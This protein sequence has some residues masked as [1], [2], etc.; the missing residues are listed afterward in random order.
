MSNLR[1]LGKALKKFRDRVTHEVPTGPHTDVK[2][3]KLNPSFKKR[4]T[5]VGPDIES[6]ITKERKRK[7]KIMGMGLK[8]VVKRMIGQKEGGRI[9]LR[10][11]TKPLET[12]MHKKRAQQTQNVK[13]LTTSDDAYSPERRVLQVEKKTPY[14]STG[15]RKVITDWH[16]I[17]EEGKKLKEKFVKKH[18][19]GTLSLYDPPKIR[20]RKGKKIGAA[21]STN[22]IKLQQKILSKEKKATGGRI[23][24]AGGSGS[25]PRPHGPHMWVKTS[26]A[27]MSGKKVGIQIK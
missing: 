15:T 27:V 7:S 1:S 5:G 20:P 25:R 10:E 22:L 13:R 8:N 21:K 24:Y 19:R 4:I 12:A 18:G 11:G 16:N 23:G 3:R 26:G 14:G 2:R 9:G 6:G 17:K